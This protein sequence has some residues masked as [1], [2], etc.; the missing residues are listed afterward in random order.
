MHIRS[1]LYRRTAAT[2][3]AGALAIAPAL[4]SGFGPTLVGANASAAHRYS[5][6]SKVRL[7][8]YKYS[9]GPVQIR[10]VRITQGAASLAVVNAASTFGHWARPSTIAMTGYYNGST[11][12]PGIAATNGDFARSLMPLHQEEI[13]GQVMTTGF[14]SSPQFAVNADGSRAYI[15]SSHLRSTA[16]FNATR[17][18][19]HAWNVGGPAHDQID[20]YT[21]VGGS[22]Q[23]PPGTTTPTA[24]DPAHCAV[25]L[26]PSAQPQWSNHAKAGIERTYT[27]EAVGTSPCL[28]TPMPLGTN[29]DAVVLASA[30]T[31]VG[32]VTLTTLATCGCTVT[33]GWRHTGWPGV[34]QAVGGTPLLVDNGQNVAPSFSS[35]DSYLNNYNPRTA[36]GF[37][38]DCSDTDP[39]TLCRIYLVTVDG[40]QSKWSVGLRMNRLGAFFVNTLHVQYALNLDGGGA[41]EMWVHKKTSSFTP[42]CITSALAGCLVGRPADGN[43]RPS[44]MALVVVPGTDQ[45]VPLS[46]R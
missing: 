32:A 29:P 1:P 39:L 9:K 21:Q 44:I 12:G 6:G 30:D 14:Q 43:E 33:L 31:G 35:G 20:G 25:R 41:S 40:R 2:V 27:V 4:S 26:V 45:R 11:Y 42:P 23:P 36:I 46:L 28:K 19:V 5:L 10:V 15:G 17:F 13:G 8:T 37:N 34:V 7:T 3:L 24:T 38:A 22:V 16:T 18:R